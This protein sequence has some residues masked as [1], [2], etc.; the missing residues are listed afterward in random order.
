MSSTPSGVPAVRMSLAP[1]GARS[2]ASR[3]TSASA[4]AVATAAQ[5][6]LRAA[7]VISGPFSARWSSTPM[8]C[9]NPTATRR[10]SDSRPPASSRRRTAAGTSVVRSMCGRATGPSGPHSV[11][12]RRRR[13][14]PGPT[15]RPVS[16]GGNCA[17]VVR[18]TTTSPADAAPS[19]SVTKVASGPMI[20]SSRWDLSGEHEVET[21]GVDPLGDPQDHPSL[22][23]LDR[24][25]R[26]QR[27]AH[28][29]S[30]PARPSGVPLAV[31][32]QEECV[33]AVLEE[34]AALLAPRR[35]DP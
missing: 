1:S 7:A 27:S 16:E 24:P 23:G 34:V 3:H 29:V 21:T 31:E 5:I 10:C 25:P 13:S 20:R 6:W 35:G 11:S 26:L 22:A 33:A 14:S 28:S 9:R 17:A 2:E 30:G 4:A 8:M 18:L 15:D 19:M 32:R 12:G